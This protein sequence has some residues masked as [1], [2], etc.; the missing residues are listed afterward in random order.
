MQTIAASDA[1]ISAGSVQSS[2][3][4]STACGVRTLLSPLCATRSAMLARA[5]GSGS[6]GWNTSAGNAAA[7]C[8]T[9][10]PLPLASSSTAPLA[11]RMTP[12]HFEDRAAIAQGPKARRASRMS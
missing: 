6:L 7:K 12:Q 11:G 4:A 9:C 3:L 5:C 2:A 8:V 1:A 10:S